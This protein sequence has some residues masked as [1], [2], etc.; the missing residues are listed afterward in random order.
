MTADLIFPIVL[1]AMAAFVLNKLVRQMLWRQRTG[2]ARR[3]E[4]WPFL[5]F[6]TIGV[7]A[8]VFDPSPKAR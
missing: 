7:L 8:F 2:Q 4:F 3:R 5:L 1:L 6:L